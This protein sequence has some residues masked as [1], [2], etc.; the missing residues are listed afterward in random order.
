MV[1]ISFKMGCACKKELKRFEKYTNDA[2]ENEVKINLLDKL[3]QMLMQFCFGIV[4]GA[5]IIITVLPLLIYVI[6]CLLI[7]KQPYIKLFNIKK[8]FSKKK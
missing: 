1:Y 5:V 7:G 8:L 6:G 3:L 4:A 2:V